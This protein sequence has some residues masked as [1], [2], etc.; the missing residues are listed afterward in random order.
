MSSSQLSTAAPLLCQNPPLLPTLPLPGHHHLGVN[1]HN[2]MNHSAS[3]TSIG[4]LATPASPPVTKTNDSPI[5]QHNNYGGKN[6]SKFDFRK[7]AVAAT[8]QEP[9]S[10]SPQPL[11]STQPVTPSGGLPSPASLVRA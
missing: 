9:P 7:L 11:P 10:S 3:R 8:S 5:Q 1:H 2:N 4:R 6:S